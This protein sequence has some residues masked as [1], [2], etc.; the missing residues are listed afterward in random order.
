MNTPLFIP[1]HI[2]PSKSIFLAGAVPSAKNSKMIGFYYKKSGETSSW[3][4]KKGTEFKA[5]TPSLRSSDQTEEY[6]KDIVQQGRPDDRGIFRIAIKPK[7]D[8]HLPVLRPVNRPRAVTVNLGFTLG[9]V[10]GGLLFERHVFPQLES[11]R[12]RDKRVRGGD[13]IEDRRGDLL[14]RR[15]RHSAAAPC[16]AASSSSIICCRMS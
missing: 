11:A 6:I 3:Y 13:E 14:A 8:F 10:E 7:P 16:A 4:F 12:G 9:L 5:I 15:L 2:D 1:K